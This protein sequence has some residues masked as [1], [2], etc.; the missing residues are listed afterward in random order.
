MLREIGEKESKQIYVWKPAD[1]YINKS[2]RQNWKVERMKTKEKKISV[3]EERY[4][5]RCNWISTLQARVFYWISNH[6]GFVLVI[7][8]FD[9]H[10]LFLLI[11]F[12]ILL[13]LALGHIFSLSLLVSN[14]ILIKEDWKKVFSW[15][16]QFD[17]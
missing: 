1:G 6:E 16:N 3:F 9:L 5:F 15:F 10:H 8:F 2:R 4:A 11:C 7:P 17:W 12:S 14:R 13:R